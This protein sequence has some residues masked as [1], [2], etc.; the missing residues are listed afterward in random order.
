M[1]SY[2]EGREGCERSSWARV[3]SA[4]CRVRSCC[5]VMS[6]AL[7]SS[8]VN[9]EGSRFFSASF[10]AAVEV[11]LMKATYT[12]ASTEV[13]SFEGRLMFVLARPA[14]LKSPAL[15]QSACEKLLRASLQRKHSAKSL[16]LLKLCHLYKK[17][18]E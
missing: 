9:N 7:A 11:I 4:V 5:L 13:V 15:S 1:N 2:H 14:K 12:G 17:G 6:R 16:S 3:L 10:S 8:S 18:T